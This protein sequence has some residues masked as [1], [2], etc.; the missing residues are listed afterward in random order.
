[1]GEAN[2]TV[3]A[4]GPRVVAVVLSVVVGR[5]VVVLGVAPSIGRMSALLTASS[6]VLSVLAAA[7]LLAAAFLDEAFEDLPFF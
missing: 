6:L 7:A 5:A 2:R 3:R 4:A 1:M